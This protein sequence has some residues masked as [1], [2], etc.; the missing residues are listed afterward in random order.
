MPEVQAIEMRQNVV[1]LTGETAE[2][3]ALPEA[4]SES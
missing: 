3:E 4:S 2:P 1:R